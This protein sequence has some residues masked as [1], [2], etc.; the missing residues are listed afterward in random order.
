MFELPSKFSLTFLALHH[1]QH[2]AMLRK[3]STLVFHC[4][5]FSRRHLP[6]HKQTV[7]WRNSPIC[8]FFFAP[9]GG[10][11]CIYLRLFQLENTRTPSKLAR[12]L[13]S[14]PDGNRTDC[15]WISWCSR[16]FFTTSK[17]SPVGGVFQWSAVEDRGG[18]CRLHVVA[19]EGLRIQLEQ[20]R[21]CFRPA[22][23][24]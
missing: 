12:A 22:T 17:C 6:A 14:F 1:A 10:N 7:Q 21:L 4:L 18:C 15:R 19:G 3:A 13:H 8:F 23:G 2:K 20:I 16:F 9:L 24:M 11:S 5:S